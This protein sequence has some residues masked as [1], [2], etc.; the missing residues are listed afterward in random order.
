[1]AKATLGQ[2]EQ[3]LAEQIDAMIQRPRMYGSLDETEAQ[4]IQA[5]QFWA[6]VQDFEGGSKFVLDQWKLYLGGGSVAINLAFQSGHDEIEWR[7]RMKFFIGQISDHYNRIANSRIASQISREK[8]LEFMER[9]RAEALELE[10][11]P[12]Y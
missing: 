1:M 5:L 8:L 4:I 3:A 10:K 7:E 9:H 12:E 6:L 2:I 11:D